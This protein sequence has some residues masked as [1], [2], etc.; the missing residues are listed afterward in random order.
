LGGSCRE[1]GC[2]VDTVIVGQCAELAAQRQD[3]PGKPG[4]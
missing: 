1:V 4:A 2:D 3:R